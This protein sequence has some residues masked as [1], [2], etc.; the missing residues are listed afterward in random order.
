MHQA[1]I[2][3]LI[4]DPRSDE[5]LWCVV[6][7]PKNWLQRYNTVM[8][9]FNS[10]VPFLINLI[11]AVVL[12][13]SFIRTRQ[14]VAKKTYL[15]ILK[16]QA[17]THKDLI[18][19]PILVIICK[20]P[21]IIIAIII[22]CIKYKWHLYFSAACYFV[23]LIPMTAMFFIFIIPSTLYCQIFKSKI[24]KIFKR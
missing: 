13:V 3:E 23:A 4:P 19:S 9:L 6:K 11:S 2:R 16:E 22:K 7:F 18:V 10:I 21:I 14:K 24:A 20:L 17:E 1:F 8:S 15:S 12:L 5:R